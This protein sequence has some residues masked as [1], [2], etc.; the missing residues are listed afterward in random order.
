MSKVQFLSHALA[1]AIGLVR[2]EQLF[3]PADVRIAARTLNALDKAGEKGQERTAEF[4]TDESFVLLRKLT[5]KAYEVGA[6]GSQA[7]G[8][9]QLR[10][11]LVDPATLP[12]FDRTTEKVPFQIS[13]RAKTVLRQ[14]FDGTIVK[15][16]E[17]DQIGEVLTAL[18]DPDNNREAIDTTIRVD[19]KNRA[20]EFIEVYLAGQVRNE[21]GRKVGIAGGMAQGLV[22]LMDF[23]GVA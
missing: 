8:L 1:T 19:A 21:E 9:A 14:L 4:P 15:D 18:G 20:K 2:R 11:A 13:G 10:D 7:S 12:A 17:I 3:S 22:E 6:A 5:A 23:F 16:V